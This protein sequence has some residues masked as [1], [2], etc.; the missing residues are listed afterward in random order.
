MIPCDL[1]RLLIIDPKRQR[2]LWPPVSL[3]PIAASTLAGQVLSRSSSR[4]RSPG[5]STGLVVLR[6]QTA[7][8]GSGQPWTI[9][10]REQGTPAAELV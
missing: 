4:V 2:G 8:T 9:P 10:H 3:F 6:P 1:T 5:S 7:L